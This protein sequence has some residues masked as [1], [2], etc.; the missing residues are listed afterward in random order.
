MP[1]EATRPMIM[2]G[3]GTGIAPFRWSHPPA[4]L[5]TGGALYQ[6]VVLPGMLCQYFQSTCKSHSAFSRNAMQALCMHASGSMLLFN[7]IA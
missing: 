3:P 2:I 1:E 4:P 5:P 6:S 7:P